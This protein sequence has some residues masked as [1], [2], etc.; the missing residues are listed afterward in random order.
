MKDRTCEETSWAYARF[1]GVF[2]TY[3]ERKGGRLH[4]EGGEKGSVQVVPRIDEALPSPDHPAV[5]ASVPEPSP[6]GGRKE[7]SSAEQI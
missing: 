4:S 2:P 5:F 3:H 1:L 6:G 7:G